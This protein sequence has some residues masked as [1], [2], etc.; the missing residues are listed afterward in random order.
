MKFTIERAG[1][2]K[3]LG[4]VQRVAE[5]RHTIPILSNVLISAERGGVAFSATDLDMEIVDFAKAPVDPP[6]P[7]PA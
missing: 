7:L 5:R 2:L 3:A 4:H 6:G 1:L